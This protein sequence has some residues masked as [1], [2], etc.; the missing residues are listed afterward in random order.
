MKIEMRIKKK[1]RKSSK[2]KVGLESG[3]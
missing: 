3:P 2:R 1:W